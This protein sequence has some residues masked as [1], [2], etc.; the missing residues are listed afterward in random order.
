MILLV[1]VS[2]TNVVGYQTIQL[3]NQQTIKGKINQKNLLFQTIYDIV[4]NKEIQRIILKSQMSSGIFPASEIPILT[5]NQ[6]RQFYLLGLIISKIINKS[7]INLM[8]ERYQINSADMQK[9]IFAVIEKDP[10]LRDEISQLRNSECDCKNKNITG[11]WKFPVICMVLY[12]IFAFF[13]VLYL[14]DVRI[15]YEFVVLLDGI[16]TNLNCFWAPFLYF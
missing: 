9:E 3:S 1:L 4:N 12:A 2:L 8:V 5:K 16:G 14:F 11:L 10:T 7:R 15:A 6:L 13:Y